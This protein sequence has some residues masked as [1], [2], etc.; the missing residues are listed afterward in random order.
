V[1]QQVLKLTAVRGLGV[2]AFLVAPF[3]D[4]RTLAAAIF[5]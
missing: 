2:L 4:L 1:L 3:E 5:S